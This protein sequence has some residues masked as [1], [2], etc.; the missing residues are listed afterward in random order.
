[1]NLR[2]RANARP[3][4]GW[5]LAVP[6]SLPG[7]AQEVATLGL[8]V[9]SEVPDYAKQSE[10]MELFIALGSS[11]MLTFKGAFF[12]QQILKHQGPKDKFH[13]YVSA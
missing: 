13:P 5:G 7:A 9:H 2:S 12:L 6:G 11:K 3:E 8:C 4:G 10:E 1:M